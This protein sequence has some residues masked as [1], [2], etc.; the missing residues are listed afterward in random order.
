MNKCKRGSF[1]MTFKGFD[2][3]GHPVSLKYQNQPTY[4]SFLGATMTFVVFGGILAYFL[5]LLSELV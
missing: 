4:R 1:W 3:F 5:V 2:I